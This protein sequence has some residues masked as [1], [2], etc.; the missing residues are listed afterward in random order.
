MHRSILSFAAVAAFG[1]SAYAAPL[2]WDW[3]Y[4]ADVEPGTGGEVTWPQGT[5]QST[6]TPD[7]YGVPTDDISPA[8]IY[9]ASTL[10]TNSGGTFQYTTN[11]G[12]ASLRSA[13]GYTIEWK[14]KINSIDGDEPG[15]G[16]LAMVVEDGDPTVNSWWFIGFDVVGGQYQAELQGASVGNKLVVPVD[17]TSFHTY[18]MTVL[19]AV[20]TLYIDGALA[21]SISDPRTDIDIQTMTVGDGTNLNDSSFSTDYLYVTDDGAFAIPEPASLSLLGL[22]ALA[23][24]RRRG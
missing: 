7:L 4:D 10:G 18:R 9:N 14:M 12:L 8:G 13:T 15:N 22:G 24:L 23:M 19:G 17:N 21:G 1:A 20:T 3:Y 6:L 16:S 11:G 2:T 5:A